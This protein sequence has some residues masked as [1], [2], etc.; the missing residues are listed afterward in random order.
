MA[1]VPPKTV[2]GMIISLLSLERRPSIL[3]Y[4]S[5]RREPSRFWMRQL[6]LWC[7]DCPD[8]EIPRLVPP[9]V[10]HRP[11][12]VVREARTEVL[13]RR[14]LCLRPLGFFALSWC[15]MLDMNT[16][17]SSRGVV[18]IVAGY[19]GSR[20]FVRCGH[21]SMTPHTGITQFPQPHPDKLAV[22]GRRTS[23]NQFPRVPLHGWLDHSPRGRD[24][25]RVYR[26]ENR[27]SLSP[28]SYNVSATFTVSPNLHRVGGDR[29]R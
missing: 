1:P 2:A 10:N 26:H 6:F 14:P 7:P 8:I 15:S 9:G 17:I 18:W 19:P 3:W 24:L 29:E 25:V 13:E 12:R 4:S 21:S 11:G 28:T 23:R 20:A 16:M 22:G 27:G 5:W